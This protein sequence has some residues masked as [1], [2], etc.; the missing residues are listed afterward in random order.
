MHS[1][2]PVPHLDLETS[3]L[4]VDPEHYLAKEPN[5]TVVNFESPFTE[6]LHVIVN[7]PYV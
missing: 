3:F 2:P 6:R 5:W 4:R 7:C 1:K